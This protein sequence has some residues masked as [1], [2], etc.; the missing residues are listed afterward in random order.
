MNTK[1]CSVCIITKDVS[2]FYARR[3]RGAYQSECKACCKIRRAKWWKSDAGKLSSKNSKLKARFGISLDIY[4]QLLTDQN[5]QCFICN[6]T[7]SANG[8]SLA[9]DH[10]H[11]T[12]K[13]RG[14]LCKACNIALG[15]FKE[16]IKSL[17]NAIVYLEMAR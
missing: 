13:I 7:K 5:Y 9:V 16:D 1:S 6:K 15:N 14:L 11:K 12:G 17:Q 10:C 3:T 8:H 2:E 4:N